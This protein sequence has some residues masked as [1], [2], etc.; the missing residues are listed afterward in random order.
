ML[1]PTVFEKTKKQ[2]EK[3]KIARKLNSEAV[4]KNEDEEYE[5]EIKL[6]LK[7]LEIVEELYSENQNRWID[8]Y[9][10]VLS[11]LASV[12]FYD[13]DEIEKAYEIYKKIETIKIDDKHI[14]NISLFNIIGSITLRL[15]L[16]DEA[17][18]YFKKY[19]ELFDIASIEEVEN[20]YKFIYPFVKYYQAL[21]NLNENDKLKELD[22]LGN[23]SIDILKN[24]FENKYYEQIEELH[25][26]YLNLKDSKN[27]LE[28]EN[29]EIFYKLFLKDIN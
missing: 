4:S 29:C 18:I 1:N 27:T 9:T 5:E 28:N 16:F 15:K 17:K 21:E 7:A 19:F 3:Y 13:L 14:S 24:R 11:N 10:L 20:I 2:L 23:E 25:N 8:F 6:Y 26:N 22:Q 12:Y